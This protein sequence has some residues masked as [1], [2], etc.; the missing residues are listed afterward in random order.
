[1]DTSS[2]FSKCPDLSKMLNLFHPNA[3]F[4]DTSV[5]EFA[6]RVSRRDKKS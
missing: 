1:M 4:A 2:M 3:H 5:T 6:S